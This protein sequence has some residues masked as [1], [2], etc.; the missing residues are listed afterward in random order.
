MLFNSFQFLAFFILVYGLYRALPFRWQNPVL[1]AASYYFYGCWDWRFL[2]LIW[3][4]SSVDYFLSRAIHQASGAQRRRG[5]LLASVAANLGILF[6]FKYFGFFA[7][8]LRPLLAM[9]GMDVSWTTLNIVLPV[10]I[11]F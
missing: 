4:S 10:G 11:S 3:F 6:A 9:L 2:A 1:L 8:S 7:A 5:L